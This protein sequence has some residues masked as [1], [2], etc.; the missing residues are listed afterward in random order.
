MS[1][2]QNYNG[3]NKPTANVE[4][5]NTT[6]PLDKNSN[7]DAATSSSTAP[8]SNNA[9][10]SAS[11]PFASSPAPPTGSANESA[12]D[13]LTLD[14]TISADGHGALLVSYKVTNRG[15]APV[16][17]LNQ[18][19]TSFGLGAGRVYIE[20]QADGSVDLTQRGFAVPSSTQ[21]PTPF[22]AIYPG[23]ATLAAGQTLNQNLK[24]LPPLARRHPYMQGA[25]NHPMPDPLKR[26][27]FC[28]GVIESADA[29]TK[30]SKGVRVLTS[31]QAISQQRLLCSPVQE[32]K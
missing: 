27:R 2:S 9:A 11:T 6:Q 21:G 17:L 14:A 5:N 31:L 24:V 19:D 28:L 32:L 15:K 18:G 12:S 1:N 20:P 3:S 25:P 10:A 16:L 23:V 13:N 7:A 4:T 8:A 22:A 26:V 29:P 30:I